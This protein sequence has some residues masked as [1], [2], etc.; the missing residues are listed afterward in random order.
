MILYNKTILLPNLR[1]LYDLLNNNDNPSLYTCKCMYADRIAIKHY[2]DNEKHI[3][4]IWKTKSVFD[5]WYDPYYSKNFI[6]CMDYTVHDIFIKINYIGINDDDPQ[7]TYSH[8]NALDEYDAEDLIQH[9]LNFVKIIATKENK[10]KITMDVHENLRL[11][12]KYYYYNGFKTTDN[13]CTDNPFWVET[14][15]IL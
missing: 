14:E 15:L 13:K 2:I 6:A 4:Q 3:I 8:K 11:Y 5:Y 10:L 9:L 12:M 1:A 7:H